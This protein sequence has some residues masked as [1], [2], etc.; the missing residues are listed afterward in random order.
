MNE[1]ATGG[2]PPRRKRA[3]RRLLWW[4]TAIFFLVLAALLAAF[5]V[6][7]PFYYKSK[8]ERVAL[9]AAP[10]NRPAA[11]VPEQQTEPHTCGL[12]ALSSI[13]RA[14]G[15]DPIEARLRFRLG[16][17]KPAT[18]FDPTSLGTI[19]PDILRVAGQ[20][21]FDTEVLLMSGDMDA[22]RL[23]SHL[24]AGHVAMGLVR[25][26][27]LHWIVLSGLDGES[28]AVCDSL[29]TDTYA[30]PFDEIV[31]DRLQSAI[32]LAPKR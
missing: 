13:Y 11:L 21:G 19:H 1:L 30:E 14:Y 8:Y 9:N 18:N 6:G 23:R 15:L 17:D 5:C 25:L 22:A 32:L 3:V 7:S 26:G 27:N 4:L 12:H 24:R 16:V 28:V 20:D 2:A 10:S 31:R 29:R